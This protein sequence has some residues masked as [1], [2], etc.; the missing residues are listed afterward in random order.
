MVTKETLHRLIDDLPESEYTTAHRVLEGLRAL[1][2]AGAL[3]SIETAPFDDEE[4]TDEERA[5]VAE[6][7]AALAR[8]EVVGHDAVRRELGL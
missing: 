4:E 3:Y 7:R 2:Q 8:G 6:A 1:I 5:A